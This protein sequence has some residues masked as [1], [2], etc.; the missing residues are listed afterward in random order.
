MSMRK[1][2]RGL[3]EMAATAATQIKTRIRP[4][5]SART[6]RTSGNKKVGSDRGMQPV[7]YDNDAYY[8]SREEY[9]PH[10]GY[11]LQNRGDGNFGGYGVNGE[12]QYYRPN[13]NNGGAR[14]DTTRDRE[15]D[16]R[17]QR[18]SAAVSNHLAG[19]GNGGGR[20]VY[21]EDGGAPPPPPG[22]P[23]YYR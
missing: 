18:A 12:N 1:L 23:R 11:S 22:P 4:T 2:L 7:D 9:A 14:K 21:E 16:G 8:I 10:G 3:R 20:D 15:R 13:Q 5:L 6:I 19:G 17:T